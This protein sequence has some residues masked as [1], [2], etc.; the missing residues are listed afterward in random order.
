M[1]LHLYGIVITQS[2]INNLADNISSTAAI[3][4]GP[5]LG[6]LAVSKLDS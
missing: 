4:I 6:K 2:E 3:F 5:V 1:L